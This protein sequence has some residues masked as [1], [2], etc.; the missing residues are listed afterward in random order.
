MSD[1]SGLK[2]SAEKGVKLGD[3]GQRIVFEN[4][5]VRIWE[6]NL[7]PGQVQDFHLHYH[8]YV[9][10]SL[11]GGENEIETIFG[12]KRMTNEPLGSTVFMNEMRPVHKL[13]NKSTAR[14][15]SRLIELKH[16]HWTAE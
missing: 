7:E 10:I 15:L 16:I 1:K 2:A 12:D 5:Q 4:E 6:I 3:V 9:I 11:G 13:T 8:P 14:Y